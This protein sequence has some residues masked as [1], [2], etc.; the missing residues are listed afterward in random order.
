[1]INI[2]AP[3]VAP[4]IG[5]FTK[6]AENKA[7]IAE[8]KIDRLMSADDKVATWEEIHAEG[9]QDSWKDELWTV[10]FAVPLIM[11]FIPGMESYVHRGFA[12]LNETPEWYQ[13]TLMTL[14]FAS[15][16]IRWVKK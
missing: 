4:V 13:Y 14:V 6:R 10:V 5:Y 16:G 9:S 12:V 8:K 7:K 11:C 1:M 3:L 15:V 2:L